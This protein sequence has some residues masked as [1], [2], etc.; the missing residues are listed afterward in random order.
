MEKAAL[1]IVNEGEV[2]EGIRAFLCASFPL[3]LRA[4][5]GHL[6][7]VDLDG[8]LSIKE[9]PNNEFLP[10][11]E[12]MWQGEELT[13]WGELFLCWAEGTIEHD[14]LH[15]ELDDLN[16]FLLRSRSFYDTVAPV[17]T[18]EPTEPKPE[19]KPKEKL[20]PTV[21]PS[22]EEGDVVSFSQAPTTPF[23][24]RNQ[25]I[26]RNK[27]LG[28]GKNTEGVMG[29]C[30]QLK[31]S[32]FNEEEMV[33]RLESSNPLLF[34]FPNRLSGK[35]TTVTYWLPPVAFPHPSGHL[36]IRTA[37]ETKQLSLHSLFPKSRT[38][39]MRARQVVMCLLAPALL[40]FLYFGFV[41][42]VT[43]HGID[44]ETRELFP[45]LY[46][47][48]VAG[49][50]GV[51]F[52]AHGLGLYQLKVIPAS[53][54]LQMIWAGIIFWAPLLTN[55]FFRYVSKSRQRRLAGTYAAALL[56][57]MALM[58]A[59]WTFQDSFFPLHGHPDFSPLDL[60]QFLVWS[61][62]MN[63]IGGI[64]LFLSSFR[65]I[66]KK[67]KPDELRIALPVILSVLYLVIMFFV[68]YGRSWAA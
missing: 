49:V 32:F 27:F 59:T 4:L 19:P 11:R 22:D 26:V 7:R 28:Y 57:P 29:L 64:Y 6:D 34:L 53:E 16:E 36:T 13:A 58:L 45:E 65:V 54:S 14:E 3:V 9:R 68:I 20:P 33:G 23:E 35:S 66:D 56:M 21:A 55:K 30:G 52:K 18:A 61:I 41:Y 24:K 5:E 50:D 2:E 8:A 25:V 15:L 63:I 42:L 40:G 47:A 43:V 39:L 31:L 37:F 38:D 1:K 67:I 44:R 62:P 60:R 51:D 17:R 10:F 46:K 48:A 12:M